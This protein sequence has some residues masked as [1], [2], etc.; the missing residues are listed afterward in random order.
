MT[1]S[2]KGSLIN[3]QQVPKREKYT[4]F[5]QRKQEKEREKKEIKEL[6]GRNKVF[7][8]KKKNVKKDVNGKI[9]EI[10]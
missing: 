8:T 2:L 10:K 7:Y 1:H 6:L 5:L 4:L 3:I 9:G